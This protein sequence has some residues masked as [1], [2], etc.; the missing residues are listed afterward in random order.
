LE[1]SITN[2]IGMKLVLIPAGTFIMGSPNNEQDR[3]ADEGPQHEVEITRAFY[4][5]GFP[6]TKGQFAAFVADTGYKR[7]FGKPGQL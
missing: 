5:G 1:Q 4:M 3:N 2:S 7:L 6:V